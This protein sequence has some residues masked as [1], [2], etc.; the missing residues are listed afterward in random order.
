M[1]THNKSEMPS[2]VLEMRIDSKNLFRTPMPKQKKRSAPWNMYLL[3]GL[4]TLVITGMIGYLSRIEKHV[5]VD[6]IAVLFLIIGA[7]LYLFNQR[8]VKDLV[9]IK[10]TEKDLLFAAEE[11]RLTFDAI[12][13]MISI[14]NKD[15][16]IIRVNK[17][18]AD[19]LNMK[20]SEV[21]GKYCYELIHATKGPQLDCPCNKTFEE[22]KPNYSEVF[23]P[24]L[25]IHIG[26]STSPIFDENGQVKASIHIAK[27]ITERKQV[28]K[29]I[30][31]LS[32]FPSE[33]PNP[34]LRISKDGE[35]L[36]INKAGD[37]L[38]RKLKSGA[39]IIVPLEWKNLIT[40]AVAL[41][42]VTE[43]EVEVED[44]IFSLTINPIKEAEYSNLY[45]TDITCR[46]KSEYE[47]KKA[48]EDSEAANRAKSQF[49]ANM[50]HEIRTPMNAIM[51]YSDILVDEATEDQKK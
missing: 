5:L 13:D 34:V 41:G 43:T 35:I 11:W 20:P 29:E 46:K 31:A 19:A 4:L 44:R 42:K 6:V 9:R 22:G 28:Q 7:I 48:K 39:E 8:R 10:K 32:K 49:L 15:F 50:S 38:L 40:E 17:A 25:G 3:V 23:E 16:K 12:S 14:H 2:E 37:L 26:A 1:N 24:N 21:I 36:Y 30:E 45:A 33:N 47:L 51:G 18:F 27:D